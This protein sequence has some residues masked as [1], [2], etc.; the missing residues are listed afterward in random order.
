MTLTPEQA[1]TPKIVIAESTEAYGR[2]LFEPLQQ[3]FGATLGNSLRRV[4]L[5]SLPGTAVTAVRIEGV[6]H[7]YT[8][9]AHVREDMIDILLNVKGIR[10]RSLTG[11]PGVLRLEVEGHVGPVTAGDI[12][13]SGE[14]IVVNPEQV[15]L[16]MD[17]SQG[18]LAAELYV[19]QGRGYR[20]ADTR[21]GRTIGLLPV[22]AI[23]TPIRR[24]NFEVEPTRVGQVTDYDRLIMEVWTDRTISAQDAI[25]R[26]AQI[27]IDHLTPFAALGH[28]ELALGERKGAA[29]TAPT[30]LVASLPLEEL[31]LSSRTQNALRRGGITSVSQILERSPEELLNLRNFGDRSLEEL[32][33]RLRATNVPVPEG[34]D[35]TWRKRPLAEFLAAPSAPVPPAP[36]EVA[37]AVFSTGPADE[38]EAAAETVDLTAFRRRTFSPDD[39]PESLPR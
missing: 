38:E 33:E 18:R 35:K 22:D 15:L 37:P 24:V 31:K 23:F 10:L 3:G 36:E 14:H 12:Q 28:P 21:D 16:H 7:E 11:R 1:L 27:L 13:P 20:S 9:L 6:Q 26:A 34:E 30:S 4:L 2:F 17:N 5:S 29:A 25:R 39:E 32:Y 8:T 19:E